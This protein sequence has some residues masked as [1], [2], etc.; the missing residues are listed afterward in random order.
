[1]NHNILIIEDDKMIIDLMQRIF[2]KNGFNVDTV[3]NISD[4]Y[5]MLNK[6]KYKFVITDII[7]HGKTTGI[8]LC[9]FIKLKFP[10]TI[11]IGMSGF[12]LDY[13]DI[14]DT[15]F[16][17]FFQKPISFY[18]ITNYIKRECILIK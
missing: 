18:T 9:N 5:N 15:V 10:K 4:C 12:P 11:V 14:D 6:N 1:M 3:S 8:D 13:F 16:D 2:I 7:F 17:Q